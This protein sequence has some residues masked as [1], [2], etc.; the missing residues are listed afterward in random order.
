MAKLSFL[1]Y[2]WLF[3]YNKSGNIDKFSN[4]LE[5]PLKNENERVLLSM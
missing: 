1:C 4:N 3:N 5:K 2:F